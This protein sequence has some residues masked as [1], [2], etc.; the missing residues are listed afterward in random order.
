VQFAVE[1]HAESHWL[2]Q[3]HPAWPISIGCE[4]SPAC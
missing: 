4:G 3:P 1:Y 2:P